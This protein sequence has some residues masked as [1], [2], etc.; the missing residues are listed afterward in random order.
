[1]YVTAWVALTPAT[2][3]SSCLYFVPA[4]GDAGY[5]EAGDALQAA[6]PSPADWGSIVAQ[7]C[8]PGDTMVRPLTSDL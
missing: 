3:E 7:P 8:A 6:L 2:P 1:M 5:A 4:G